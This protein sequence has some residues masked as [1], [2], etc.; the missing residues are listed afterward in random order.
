VSSE[1]DIGC[2][3]ALHPKAEVLLRRELLKIFRQICSPFRVT[4]LHT[5]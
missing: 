2:S 3:I 1:N 5:T 4:W